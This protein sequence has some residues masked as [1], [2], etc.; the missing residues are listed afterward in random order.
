LKPLGDGFI[1]L[2]KM[3]IGPI[4]FCTVVWN[5]FDSRPEKL[6]R[7]GQSSISELSHPGTAHWPGGGERPELALDSTSIPRRSIPG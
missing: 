5:R 3:M 7:L 6:G 2:V 4:I 1:K